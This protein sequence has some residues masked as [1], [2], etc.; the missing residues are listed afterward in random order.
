MAAATVTNQ[1][2]NNVA[3]SLVMILADTIT[4]ASNSDTWDSGL[5]SINAI[6]LTPTT[7]EAFGFTVSGG[8]ITLID[9]NAPVTFRGG[10]LGN[11]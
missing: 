9:T 3:G 10:V 5:N 6:L 8:T 11:F 2:Q 7:E 1:R 4:F